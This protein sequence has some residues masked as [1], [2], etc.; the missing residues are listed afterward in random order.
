MN[1]PCRDVRP[2]LA[3]HLM[4]DVPLPQSVAQHLDRCPEC[5]RE[6]SE[7]TDVVR[8][9]K[10]AAPEATVLRRS[11]A[12][13]VRTRPD[14]GIRIHAGIVETG[15]AGARRRHRVALGAA[16][17]LAAIAAVFIPLSINH[18]SAPPAMAFSLAREGRM[19]SYTWGTEVP[20]ALTGLHP[21]QTYRLMTA[22][23]SGHSTPGGSVRGT[24]DETVHTRIM[25][26]M[27]RDAIAALLV[28]DEN[29]RVLARMPIVPPFSPAAGVS[30]QPR[31]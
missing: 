13:A 25:T 26:A 28:E 12:P 17:V 1:T 5:L 9:L 30:D 14:R 23:S 27:P 24:V 29:G 10:R 31:I 3:E 16:A 4:L 8:T 2:V 11:G 6:A 21:G 20:V 19:V 7:I 18:H 15:R 22:D